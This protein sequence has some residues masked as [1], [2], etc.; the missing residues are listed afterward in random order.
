MWPASFFRKAQNF[1][2][3]RWITPILEWAKKVTFPGF[4]KTPLYDVGTFFYKGIRDGAINTRAAAVSFNLFLAL[5]PAVIFIFTLIPVIPMKNFQN[6]LLMLIQ[7]MV[8]ESVYG[9]I[10][11]TIEKIITIPH[12]SLLSIG[13]ILAL[14]FSTNGI[15][16]LIQSFNASVNISDTRSWIELRLIS[17]LLLIILI[18]LVTTAISLIIFTQRFLDFLVKEDIMREN[19]TY[20]LITVGKWIVILALFYFAFSFLF[21]LGP[22]RKS[23]WRF[24]SAGSTLATTLSI[25]ISLIFSFY[26]DH[27]GKYNALYGSIGAL[28]VIMLM[29]NLNCQSLIIGFELNSS[30]M[31]ARRKK[32]EGENE[33]LPSPI[34]PKI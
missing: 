7:S 8:P 16:S 26:I 17:M 24:I 31:A 10:Q 1:I 20:Y 4:D 22:A 6:E 30:I 25:L 18:L 5:F 11:K 15:L 12:G 19:F 28:P 9:S 3:I 32:L 21:Y 2:I 13:F 29:I 14:F 33:S 23:K 27:F 34:S